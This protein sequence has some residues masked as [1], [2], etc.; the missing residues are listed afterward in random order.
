MID[1]LKTKKIYSYGEVSLP[2]YISK[3]QRNIFIRERFV[4]E[5]V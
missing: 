4:K 2:L 1:W 5:L 3:S